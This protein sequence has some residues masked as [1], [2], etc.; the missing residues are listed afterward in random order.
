MKTEITTNTR[1][2][3]SESL[4]PSESRSTDS[5][6]TMNGIEA[7]AN[8]IKTIINSMKETDEFIIHIPVG[9]VTLA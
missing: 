1:L 4:I 5:M 9:G 7:S 8:S 3:D 6:T 2:P